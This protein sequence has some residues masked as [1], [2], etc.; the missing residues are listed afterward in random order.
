MATVLFFI[1]I[2]FVV[3]VPLAIG[4][5]QLMHYRLSPRGNREVWRLLNW[6]AYGKQGAIV[7]ALPRRAARS[8]TKPSPMRRQMRRQRFAVVPPGQRHCQH[9]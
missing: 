9:R 1:V 3:A 4:L 5:G 8:L 2:Y 7:A 6:E